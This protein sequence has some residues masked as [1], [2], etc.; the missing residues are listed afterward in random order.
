M[1]EGDVIAECFHRLHVVGGEDDGLAL[2]LQAEHFVL[3]DAGIHR[4][5]TAEGLVEDQQ[6]RVVDHGRDELHLLLH[7]LGELL[8]LAV[9]PAHDV[10]PLEPDHQLPMCILLRQTPQLRQ[11]HRLLTH[12]HLLV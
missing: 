3:H 12:L 8:H 5:E 1:D 6:V 9:V 7:P 10:E 2:L 11:I 4:V